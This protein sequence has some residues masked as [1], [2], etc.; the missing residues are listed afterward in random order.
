MDKKN[1][2]THHHG[3]I[4]VVATAR[5]I[6]NNTAPGDYCY[7]SED[8]IEAMK[9]LAS[10]TFIQANFMAK[11]MRDAIECETGLEKYAEE[12]QAAL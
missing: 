10:I 1:N 9:A 7:M 6:V 4:E 8:S 5:Y 3:W 12:A 11:A 2:L